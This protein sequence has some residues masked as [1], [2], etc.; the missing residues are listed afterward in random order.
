MHDC[1]FAHRCSKLICDK[2]CPKYTEVSY[3]LDRNELTMQNICFKVGYQGINRAT[4]IIERAE[5]TALV[6]ISENNPEG[7]ADLLTYC[8]ICK[9]GLNSSMHCKVYHLNLSDYIDMIRDSW[10]LNTKTQAHEYIDIW[11]NSSNVLIISGFQ[12]LRFNDFECQTL[13]KLLDMRLCRSK[14]TIVVSPRLSSLIDNSK[15]FM[16]L[17]RQK[18]GGMS[19]S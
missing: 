10:K 15:D 18:L 17:L 19:I 1:I 7:S 5:N 16:P 14:T 11:I 6:Y 8:A 9:Y 2:S 12:Y 4:K 13:L 3:L